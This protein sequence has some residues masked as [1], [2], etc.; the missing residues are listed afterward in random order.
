MIDLARDSGSVKEK[1]LRGYLQRDDY[2]KLLEAK[3]F[4]YEEWDLDRLEREVRTGIK[5]EAPVY[6]GQLNPG[7]SVLNALFNDSRKY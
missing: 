5:K 6:I 4:L 3:N 2:Q 1:P 7:D